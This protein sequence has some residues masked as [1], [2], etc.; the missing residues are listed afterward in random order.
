MAQTDPT[1]SI[2]QAFERSGYPT[3]QE[4]DDIRAKALADDAVNEA[5]KREK[6]ASTIDELIAYLV[7]NRDHIA[8][9]IFTA[10]PFHG[11][12]LIDPDRD[13]TDGRA[14]VTFLDSSYRHSCVAE[15]QRAIEDSAKRRGGMPASLE[16]LLGGL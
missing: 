6:M 1:R 15:C 8:G 9:I 10:Q 13:A 4:C 5:R 2:E 3:V 7:A 11:D 16:A 14:Q 12:K